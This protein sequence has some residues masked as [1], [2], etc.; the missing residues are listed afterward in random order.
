MGDV[1]AAVDGY[2]DIPEDVRGRLEARMA[3]RQYDDLVSIR[4]DGIEG[5]H[6]YRYDGTIREMHFGTRELC[7]SVTRS[8]WSPA[9]QERGLVY[10]DSGQCILVPT[11]CRNVSRITRAATGGDR[12]VAPPLAAAAPAVP[13]AAEGNASPLAMD[14]SPSFD[15][16][17]AWY[18]P[19][20]AGIS[21]VADAS[22][23]SG[24]NAIP[25]DGGAPVVTSGGG[26]TQWQSSAPPGAGDGSLPPV[27]PVPEPQTWALLSM[28]LVAV[29]LLKARKARRQFCDRP[30]VKSRQTCE[31]YSRDDSGC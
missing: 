7:H 21:A 5:Q 20:G 14:D 12:A 3:S 15:S 25:F 23:G 31:T 17:I 30:S 10:C 28:G 4:R 19:T 8:S 9:M 29:A 2:R 18:G 16:P 24:S 13:A 22:A 11:V 27:T 1:V 6:G 26:P